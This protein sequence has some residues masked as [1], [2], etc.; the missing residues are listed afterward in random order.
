MTFEGAEGEAELDRIYKRTEKS[1][2]L[3]DVTNEKELRS[4]VLE[5]KLSN[6]RRGGFSAKL[7][8]KLYS[9]LQ[10]RRREKIDSFKKKS[11]LTKAKV[12]IGKTLK[13]TFQAVFNKKIQKSYIVARDNKGRFTKYEEKELVEFLHK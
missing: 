2:D 11:A 3:K 7:S 8:D 9:V 6:Q 13:K 4:A 12:N 10:Q 5:I 1:V